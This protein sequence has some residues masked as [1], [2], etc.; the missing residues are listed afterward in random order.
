LNAI[1]EPPRGRPARFWIGTGKGENGMTRVTFAWEPVPVVAGDRREF[2]P[3]ARVALTA[4]AGD[5]RPFFKGNVPEE[6]RSPSETPGTPAPVSAT[7]SFDAPPGQLQ[8]R[9][10]VEGAR[11]Q[12]IDAVTR[13]L[14]LPDFTKVEVSFGTPRVFMGRTVRDISAIKANPAAVPTADREFSRTERLLIRADAYTP[15]ALP[16]TITARLL[17]RSGQ[18]M[19]DLPVTSAA[20]APSEIDLPLASLPVGDYLIELNAKSESGT[21]QELLAFKIGR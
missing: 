7:T 14:T 3:P 20:G 21:A 4:T 6:A 11:G 5:G 10:Q 1:A 19:S 2:E 13:E 18:K 17:N 8:L 9:I 12:V 16:A 15:G